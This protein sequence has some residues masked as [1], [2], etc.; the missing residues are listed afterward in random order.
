MLALQ[1]SCSPS[2]GLLTDTTAWGLSPN[3]S[4]PG[5]GQ[6]RLPRSLSPGHVDTVPSLGPH[7]A[8]PLCVSMF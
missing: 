5:G 6:G 3:V 8:V 4:S 7:V 1:Y 2:P